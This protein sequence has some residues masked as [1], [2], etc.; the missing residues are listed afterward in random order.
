ML[1]YLR[2]GMR[3]LSLSTQ[4]TQARQREDESAID[5]DVVDGISPYRYFG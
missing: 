4:T 5:M 2:M 1:F 3:D